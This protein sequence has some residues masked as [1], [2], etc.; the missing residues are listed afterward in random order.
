M[1]R[2]LL[3]SQALS[4]SLFADASNFEQ[5]FVESYD[6]VETIVSALK[7][8]GMRVVLTSGSFDIIHEGHSMYLEAARGFG[9]FLIVGLDSDDKIRSRKGPDR[10]A[11]PQM[12][13]LRMVTHQRGV[14][15]VTLKGADHPRWAADQGRRARTCWSPPR[16]P[17]PRRRSPSWRP[18]TAAGSRSWSGWRRSAPRPGCAGSSSASPSRTPSPRPPDRVRTDDELGRAGR[19]EAASALPAR[20][21]PRLRGLLR[22][23]PRRRQRA[24]ARRRLPAEFPSLAKDIRALPADR[25]ARYLRAARPGREMRVIEPADLPAAVTGDPLVLPDEEIIRALAAQHDLGRG[26]T[27]VFDPT[28]LRWDREW[29]RAQRPARFDGPIAAGDLPRGLIARARE[30]AGRSSDWWRQ[31]GAIAV[32]GADLLGY[33]LEPAPPDRVLALRRRRPAGRLQPRGPRPTCAP[34]STPRRPSSP[35][36][37]RDGVSLRGADL[38]VTT[39]PCPACARLIAEAGLRPVLLRRARTRCS[40]ARTCCAPPGS[41]CSG[42]IRRSRSDP[43]R[44]AAFPRKRLAHVRLARA[45]NASA[46]TPPRHGSRYRTR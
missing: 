5:R 16:T 3:G 8:L 1:G 38:Y 45:W 46:E 44:A 26:R 41:S 19:S 28:F 18:A 30:L 40:T 39:F 10:P 35:R 36:A 12:E 14:G 13:R 15:L 2:P 27:L 23:A 24:A 6:Q 22:P 29:S 21:P 34:P 17:T 33:G 9:D 20:H 32:R 4:S 7:T 42:S 31:V 37:A 11:V 25:A 43:D